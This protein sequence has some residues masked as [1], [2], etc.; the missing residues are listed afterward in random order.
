MS[1]ASFCPRCGEM[2][3]DGCEATDEH[4]NGLGYENHTPCRCEEEQWH[5]DMIHKACV[6]LTLLAGASGWG[7]SLA[8]SYCGDILLS[9]KV[10]LSAPVLVGEAP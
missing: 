7:Y 10:T 9:Y 8:T 4:G 6:D 2:T 1:N 3:S 5:T